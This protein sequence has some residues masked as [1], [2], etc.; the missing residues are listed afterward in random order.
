MSLTTLTQKLTK[1]NDLEV[2]LASSEQTAIKLL[3][4]TRLDLGQ[5]KIESLVTLIDSV[6]PLRKLIHTQLKEILVD[7][8]T[9]II[10]EKTGKLKKTAQTA[11]VDTTEQ[12][13]VSPENSPLPANS[14]SA[15][16]SQARSSP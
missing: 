12:E 2:D 6:T 9:Q 15:Q 10:A 1:L 16:G 13:H 4:A 3:S 14:H 7:L 8:Q 11:K 5:D